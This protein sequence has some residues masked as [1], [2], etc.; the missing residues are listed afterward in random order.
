MPPGSPGEQQDQRRALVG[1]LVRMERRQRRAHAKAFASTLSISPS[2]LSHLE[3]GKHISDDTMRDVSRRLDWA[4]FLT[5]VFGGNLDAAN[6][7]GRVDDDI[8]QFAIL[9]LREIANPD[10]YRKPYG[11]FTEASGAM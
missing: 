11:G 8:R 4:S 2:T 7:A 6:T 9:R 10:A 1:Q 3:T 5:F